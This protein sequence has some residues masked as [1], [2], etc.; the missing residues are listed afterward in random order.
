MYFYCICYTIFTLYIYIYIYSIM[1]VNK[2]KRH[3]WEEIAMENALRSIK[4]E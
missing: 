1:A 2:T 4:E 3:Q